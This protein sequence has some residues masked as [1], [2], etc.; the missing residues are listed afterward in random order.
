MMLP[1]RSSFCRRIIRHGVFAARKLAL[2]FL[3]LR[4]RRGFT[5]R[6]GTYGMV[7]FLLDFPPNAEQS[8]CLPL[9]LSRVK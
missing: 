9:G 5:S 2:D 1:P 7:R 6:D 8:S 3:D 4:T